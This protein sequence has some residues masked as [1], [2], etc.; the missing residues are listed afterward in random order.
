MFLKILAPLVV[1][2][3]ALIQSIYSDQIDKKKSLKYTINGLLIFSFIIGLFILNKDNNDSNELAK[4]QKNNIDSLRI[5]NSLLSIKLDSLHSTIENGI[6]NRGKQ[7]IE[8]LKKIN[9]LNNKLEPFISIALR[10]YPTKDKNSALNKLAKDIA[11][12]KK[13][14]EPPSLILS[15][16]EIQ[17]DNDDSKSLILQ[18]TPSKN[19]TLG[20]IEFYAEIE[21]NSSSKILDFW[22]DTKGGTFSSGKDSKKINPDGK[23]ARLIYSLI[24]AGRPTFKLKVS[25]STNVKISGNYLTKPLTLRIE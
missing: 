7:E 1:L 21:N 12:T 24:G 3:I 17:K 10:K 18:F 22:P 23:T 14:A 4:K 6:Q 15:G 11:I 8:M 19:E 13:L 16:R 20:L 9:E 25:K 5:E 2:L